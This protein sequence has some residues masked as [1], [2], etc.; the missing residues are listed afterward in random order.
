MIWNDL[1]PSCFVP[2]GVNK[3]SASD[4]AK[5]KEGVGRVGDLQRSLVEHFYFIFGSISLPPTNITT[6]DKYDAKW[7]Q[8]FCRLQFVHI[9]SCN[10]SH[11]L[12]LRQSDKVVEEVFD[13]MWSGSA[14]KISHSQVLQPT[15]RRHLKSGGEPVYRH[16]NGTSTGICIEAT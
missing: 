9:H 1:K 13:E 11:F 12:A 4:I 14:M 8:Y 3:V 10:K 2:A 16:V 6:C 7:R 15:P 5:G